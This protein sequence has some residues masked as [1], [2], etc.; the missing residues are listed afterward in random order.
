MVDKTKRAVDE[1][2]DKIQTKGVFI[3]DEQEDPF[4]KAAREKEE[5]E[6][7]EDINKRLAAIPARFKDSTFE[8]YELSNEPEIRRRQERLMQLLKSGISIIM[9]GSNGTGKTRL[10]FASY[11]KQVEE[12]KSAHYM[13]AS[14]LFDQV[15][16]SFGN[17]DM[18]SVI[19]DFAYYDYLIIDEVDKSYGSPTEF[20]TLSRLVDYRYLALKTTIL[21]ANADDNEK[22]DKYVIPVCGRSAYERIVED[23]TAVFMDWPSYRGK[24]HGK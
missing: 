14:E 5:R 15:R 9:Y 17:R 24:R 20:I 18:T 19:K 2:M 4:E 13:T 21:I 11:R 10:A 23:G 16:I 12:G 6:R 22:S 8:N 3:E 7:I 1:L